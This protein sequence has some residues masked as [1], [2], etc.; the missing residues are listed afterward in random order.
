MSERSSMKM[1]I[2][3]LIM[4]VALIQ[5]ALAQVKIGAESVCTYCSMDVKNMMDYQRLVPALPLAADST[6]EPVKRVAIAFTNNEDIFSSETRALQI[7]L[8]Q[9]YSTPLGEKLVNHSLQKKHGP[10]QYKLFYQIGVDNLGLTNIR[11]A[12]QM[13]SYVLDRKDPHELWGFFQVVGEKPCVLINEYQQPQDAQFTAVH[14]LAHLYDRKTKKYI[15]DL[16]LGNE[17]TVLDSLTIEYRALLLEMIFFRE[18]KAQQEKNFFTD[19]TGKKNYR[20]SY[21]R[22]STIRT[23]ELADFAVSLFYPRQSTEALQLSAQEDTPIFDYNMITRQTEKRQFSLEVLQKGFL[24]SISWFLGDILEKS[25]AQTGLSVAVLNYV[26]NK[27]DA[28]FYKAQ[29]AVLDR[30]LKNRGYNNFYS[31]VEEQGLIDDI[32]SDIVLREDGFNKYFH[33]S[34]GPAPRVNGGGRD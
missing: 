15:A 13:P 18:Y 34:G 29:R 22:G 3:I 9:V 8:S 16:R 27:K 28:N 4:M 19:V 24:D 12:T 25:N 32:D 6:G 31:Y 30:E 10:V 21:L 5:P 14:E 2:K 17:W 33:Q 7:V 26:P 20:E 23:K 1:Q 11:T